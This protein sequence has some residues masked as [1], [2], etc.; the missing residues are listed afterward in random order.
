MRFLLYLWCLAL[1]FSACS[2]KEPTTNKP[3]IYW[4]QKISKNISNFDL[5]IADD[6]YFSLRLEHPISPMLKEATLILA[7]RHT[8]LENYDL[9]KFYYDEYLKHYS[10]VKERYFVQFL[11]L[12]SEYKS[13]KF[14]DRNQKKFIDFKATAKN[15]LVKSKPSYKPFIQ[16][17]YFN[18]ALSIDR[19]NYNTAL[20]YQRKDKSKAF[21]FYQNKSQLGQSIAKTALKKP[22]KSWFRALFE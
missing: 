17:I 21:E 8:E 18:T 19:E 14:S 5:D 15:A 12:V 13:L 2:Q 9:A 11:K 7:K 10:Q 4:Y 1:L 20:L 16:S 3:A 6:A 22:K